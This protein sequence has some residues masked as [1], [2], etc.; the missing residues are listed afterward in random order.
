[1]INLISS[2]DIEKKGYSLTLSLLIPIVN[3][4]NQQNVFRGRL[5]IYEFSLPTKIYLTEDNNSVTIGFSIL[6]LGFQISARV[7]NF[8]EGDEC[9]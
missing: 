1:M 5:K 2:G 6:G 4:I 8:L 7:K 3:R 9:E